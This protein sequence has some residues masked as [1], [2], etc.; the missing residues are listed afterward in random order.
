MSV[1]E[2]MVDKQSSHYTIF[3]LVALF[4]QTFFG[5]FSCFSFFVEKCSHYPRRI[6]HPRKV[7][8]HSLATPHQPYTRGA[9]HPPSSML[10]PIADVS[11]QDTT[12]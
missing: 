9:P 3:L 2:M 4:E 7:P 6:V 5:D 1:L 8:T 12:R 10:A 11:P